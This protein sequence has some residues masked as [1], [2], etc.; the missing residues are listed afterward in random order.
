MA[1]AKSNPKWNIGQEVIVV[2]EGR[3]NRGVITK[4]GHKLITITFSLLQDYA[5][6]FDITLD[7]PCERREIGSYGDLYTIDEYDRVVRSKAAFKRIRGVMDRH[8][9]QR[10]SEEMVV[11]FET[12]AK[13]CPEA[14]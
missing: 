11:A 1:S 8:Y 12:L 2:W 5:T 6:R 10:L 13:L 4:V 3:P 14:D 9:R 7:P